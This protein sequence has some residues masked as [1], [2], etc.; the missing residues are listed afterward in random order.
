MTQLRII[1]GTDDDEDKLMFFLWRLTFL[2][3]STRQ[4]SDLS[5][6][7]QPAVTR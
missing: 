2:A 3:W 4:R 1:D 7:T 5:P 6:A